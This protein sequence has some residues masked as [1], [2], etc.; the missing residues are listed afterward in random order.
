MAEAWGTANTYVTAALHEGMIEAFTRIVKS[1]VDHPDDV[2]AREESDPE[3]MTILKLSV[4][5]ED[6]GRVIGKEGK[7]IQAIRTLMRVIAVKQ[8]KRIRVDLLEAGGPSEQESVESQENETRSS[9]NQPQ[10]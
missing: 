6:M 9:R 10:L 5:Q 2:Q 4:H 8:G 3:G 1:L 7:I